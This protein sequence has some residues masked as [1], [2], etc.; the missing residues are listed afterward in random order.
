MSDH[1]HN[2]AEAGCQLSVNH[3]L[4]VDPRPKSFTTR[5]H[6][7]TSAFE[8]FISQPIQKIILD[9][10]NVGKLPTCQRV[11]AGWAG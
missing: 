11:F 7:M 1:Y 9:I 3:V 8:L 2:N 10:T 6:D 4:R 5:T